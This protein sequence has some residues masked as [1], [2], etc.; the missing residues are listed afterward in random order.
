MLNQIFYYDSTYLL[1]SD[2]AAL[3]SNLNY[4]V[5]AKLP[6]LQYNFTLDDSNSDESKPW[7]TQGSQSVPLIELQG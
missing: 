7:I 2:S 6:L 4:E 1:T 5:P 3:Q